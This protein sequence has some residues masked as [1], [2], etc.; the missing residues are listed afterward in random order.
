MLQNEMS[1]KWEGPWDQEGE[2]RSTGKAHIAD[3]YLKVRVVSVAE[4]Q[5][6][7]GTCLSQSNEKLTHSTLM[8]MARKH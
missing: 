2:D 4:G 3:A 6:G 8:G 7:K 1:R 5:L